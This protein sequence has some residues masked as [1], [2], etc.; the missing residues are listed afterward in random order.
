[1]TEGKKEGKKILCKPT[2][3]E[4]GE[5]R[6]KGVGEKR[7]REERKGQERWRWEE[8]RRGKER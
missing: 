4:N 2:A 7:T 5:K 8:E 1:M 6:G 3:V